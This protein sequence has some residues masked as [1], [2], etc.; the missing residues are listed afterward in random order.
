MRS[1]AANWLALR[2]PCDRV[3]R[4]AVLADRFAE[5]LGSAARLIDLGC[6]TGSN[7]R[8]LAPRL[9]EGQR[10]LC[11]DNDAELLDEA[12]VALRNWA[13]PEGWR[14]EADFVCSDLAGDL[15]ALQREDSAITASALLDLTSAPW[16]D[17]L[18]TF[19]LGRP[20][21]IALSFDGRLTWTPA[22]SEDHSILEAFL[23]HQRTDKGFGPALGPD[24]AA[25]LA[26]RLEA[27]GYRITTAA[28]DW[29]LGTSN[30]AL[31]EEMLRGFA[32]AAGERL[33]RDLSAW[34]AMRQQQARE[35]KLALTV[36]HV[37]LLALPENG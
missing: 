5:A 6:G 30:Q 11:I 20:L 23:A 19:C 13:G 26:R 37:D 33:G 16:L 14:G 35:G 27:E 31:I 12:R 36:G 17:R 24:A 22:A 2:E 10:W 8:Y 1:F 15:G 28:S 4:S 25:Y 32:Q 9:A 7:L 21:L 34:T 29:R 18:V 3:A